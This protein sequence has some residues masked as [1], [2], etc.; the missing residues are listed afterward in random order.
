M[1]ASAETVGAQRFTSRVERELTAGHDIILLV[2]KFMTARRAR[3][4]KFRSVIAPRILGAMC[5]VSACEH[6]FAQR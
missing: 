4:C 6:A 3:C 2:H 5:A 1:A